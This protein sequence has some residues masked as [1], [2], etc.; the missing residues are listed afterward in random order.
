MAVYNTKDIDTTL[1]KND[2]IP[3]LE[4]FKARRVVFVSTPL[5]ILT[6]K[7]DS[8]AHHSTSILVS[9]CTKPGLNMLALHYAIRYEYA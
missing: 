2:F 1:L 4:K 8:C 3:L 6:L 9:T 5:D 7:A